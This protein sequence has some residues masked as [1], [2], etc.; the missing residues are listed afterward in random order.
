MDILTK[1]V[2]KD[3]YMRIYAVT[4]RKTVETARK[5]HNTTP[6][7]TAA[8]GRT[9]TAGILMGGMMKEEDGDITLQL[10]GGGPAGLILAVAK[11]DGMVKGYVENP[12]ADLPLNN[13]GKLDVGGVVGRSGYLSVVKDLKMKEPY[14]GKVPI[15]TGE[16]GDDIAFYYAQSEQVPS[17]VALGVL[18][19]TDFSVKAAGGFIVQV[20]PDCDELSL[21]RLEKSIRG[22]K[23]VTALLEDG[24][25]CG[26]IIKYIMEGFEIDIL[27]NKEVGYKCDC[28]RERTYRAIKSLG[29][30]EINAIIEEDGGAEVNCHFCSKAYLFAREDLENMIKE[31]ENKR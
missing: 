5:I 4:S 9:L 22:L 10:K 24:M 3:G 27:E 7:V 25:N 8:L 18:V 23:S 6:V 14:I 29:K 31:I 1:A 26:D 28:S 15:Q 2:T 17:V 19:D 21:A 13:I 20:M 12:D 11:H 16:I 30:D